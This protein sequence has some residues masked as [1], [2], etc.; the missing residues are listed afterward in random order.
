MRS[1]TALGRKLL[2]SVAGVA[3]MLQYHLPDGSRT[4]G[5]DAFT[6]NAGGV[7]DTVFIARV[8]DGGMGS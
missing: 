5:M 4:T 7:A 1:L 8:F 2:Q 3:G 6:H